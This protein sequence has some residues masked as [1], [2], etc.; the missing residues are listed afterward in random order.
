MTLIFIWDVAAA[1]WHDH[2]SVLYNTEIQ[3]IASRNRDG[4]LNYRGQH[5]HDHGCTKQTIILQQ[6]ASF[7]TDQNKILPALPVEVTDQDSWKGW[8]LAFVC[9]SDRCVVPSGVGGVGVFPKRLAFVWMFPSFPLDFL[10]LGLERNNW[11]LL[12]LVY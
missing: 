8:R 5:Y 1:A 4:E 11:Y 2:G 6:D 10:V 7:C 9:S 12:A 3:R